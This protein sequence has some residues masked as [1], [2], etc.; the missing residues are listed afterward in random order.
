[1]TL[2]RRFIRMECLSIILRHLETVLM[3]LTN[4]STSEKSFQPPQ[5]NQLWK[6][7]NLLPRC[8]SQQSHGKSPT[9]QTWYQGRNSREIIQDKKITN[10]N[11]TR[12]FIQRKLTP[13]CLCKNWKTASRGRRRW[14]I[15]VRMINPTCG[16]MEDSK[17]STHTWTILS[18]PQMNGILGT[19]RMKRKT[20]WNQSKLST[21]KRRQSKAGIQSAHQNPVKS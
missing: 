7:S 3:I 16:L 9:V 21:R 14:N 19:L 15:Q 1:M 13:K 8:Q 17:I 6:Q 12:L 11:K 20:K 18:F 2:S 4:I 10:T 5:T